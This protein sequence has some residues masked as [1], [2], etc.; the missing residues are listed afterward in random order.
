MVVAG[1]TA[2]TALWAE[3]A[4]ARVC[5]QTGVSLQCPDFECPGGVWGWCW[6]ATGCCAE[7]LLKKICDCCVRNYP[8]VHGYCPTGTNVKCIVESCDEDPRL[9]RVAITKVISDEAGVVAAAVR[10][11]RFPSGAAL[12]VVGD[13]DGGEPQLFGAVATAL[14]V[15]LGVPL[16][17]VGR[18]PLST[19]ALAEIGRLGASDV[20]ITGPLLP[21][22]ID[23][24]LTARGLNVS[25]YGVSTDP[26]L[27]SGEIARAGR[28]RFAVQSTVCVGASDAAALLAVAAAF[29]GAVGATL[30]IGSDHVPVENT[31]FLVG[32]EAASRAGGFS[33]ASVFASG[34]V[35]QLALDL[36]DNT[37][38][39]DGFTRTV[40]LTP[41][42]SRVAINLAALGAPL[43][44]HDP[45]S[46]DR[47]APWINARSRLFREAWLAGL[48]GSLGSP[49]FRKLQAV[50]NGYEIDKLIGVAGQGLPVYSQPL[51]ERT[52]G[53]AR[54][55]TQP[56]PARF[57]SRTW[58]NS[59]RRGRHRPAP[60][61]G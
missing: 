19:G 31:V 57:A 23:E 1:G 22:S 51:A 17:L 60:P 56:P 35:V 9:Q 48:A 58:G 24:Q 46:V 42:G 2:I 55:G 20:V 30:V 6:Y 39:R 16:L 40:G 21:P 52:I 32:P 53:Q 61:Q 37:T 27:Y 10:K 13:G 15:G 5:G 34:D 12:V 59:G 18:A 11:H 43:L 45:N 29:A 3:P 7:G 33:S 28:E 54:R 26:M 36:A 47:I 50:L 38:T 44:V 14:S 49:A 25:R 8:N 41:I 4:G